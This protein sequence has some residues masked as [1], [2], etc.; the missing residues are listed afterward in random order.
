MSTYRGTRASDQDRE[1]AA[2]VLGDAFVAGRLTQD[3]L[4][5]RCAAVY[6]ATTWRELDD[7]TADLPV[8]RVAV[9]PPAAA[10]TPRAPRRPDAQKPIWLLL[11]FALLLGAV[12]LSL[13]ESAVAWT[14]MVLIL[15]TLLPP[16]TLRSASRRQR[17]Y[18]AE[19]EADGHGQALQHAAA[20][21][22]GRGVDPGP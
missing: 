4:G 15:L 1:E 19:H 12:L 22:P 14:G 2:A 9:S 20:E 5:E 8:V 3:E 21:E 13:T 7:L 18:A 6:A 10:V 16:F 11:R 17:R